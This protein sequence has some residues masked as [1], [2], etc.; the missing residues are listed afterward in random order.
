M[1]DNKSVSMSNS[2]R[3]LTPRQPSRSRDVDVTLS[4][5]AAGVTDEVRGE[6]APLKA[7]ATGA[8]TA[9]S[10]GDREN[11]VPNKRP[12]S[13]PKKDGKDNKADDKKGGKGDNEED[14]DKDSPENVVV[15]DNP[16]GI[17]RLNYCAF[18]YGLHEVLKSAGPPVCVGLYAKWGSGKSFLIH[19]L[20]K[21][22]DPD[23]REE[24]GTGELKQWFEAGY[25]DL[26]RSHSE[27]KKD[28]EKDKS[29]VRT[30]QLKMVLKLFQCRLLLQ[31]MTVPSWL[32]AL[33]I[34][35]RAMFAE[36]YSGVHRWLE[37]FAPGVFESAKDDS[38]EKRKKKREYIF[39]GFNVSR[40]NLLCH[41]RSD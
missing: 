2:Q 7:S 12:S 22:F 28:E 38:Q 39:V 37:E 20:K 14:S 33:W 10:V 9:A 6:K 25:N 31:L 27:A 17:D 21:A 11:V 36:M 19:L 34:V 5:T 24:K 16:V 41:R 40:A 3:Q 30:K 26:E 29:D 1:S 8:T 15:N 13:R 35:V 32:F 23:V 18:S 4:T